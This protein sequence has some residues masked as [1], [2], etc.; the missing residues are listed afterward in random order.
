MA[1]LEFYGAAGTVTGSHHILHTDDGPVALDAG[2]FQGKRSEYRSR[3][4]TFPAP[5]RELQALLLSHAHID[6]SGNI[7]N[8]V[9]HRFRAPVYAT[10]ATCDLCDI[11][12]A[13]SAHIQEE[14]ARFW[15]EK[16]ARS[17][18]E[19]I[20][21]LYTV[22]D[23]HNAMQYFR[24]VSYDE[25]FEFAEGCKATFVDAGHILGS[26]C[27]L[28]EASNGR[29]P[30]TLLYTGDLGRFE[31]PILRDPTCP[32][33]KVDYL[34]TECTYASRRHANPTDM[35]EQLAWI[36]NQTR[37]AGGKVIIPAFSVGRTQNV[38]YYLSQA[39]AEGLM[40]PLPVFVDSPLST[41]ATE[42]FKKHPECYDDQARSFWWS[43]GDIFGRGLVTYI[44]DVED[45]KRLN[46]MNEPMVDFPR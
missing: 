7:P 28:I 29:A 31:M 44:T 39:V 10:A 4:T 27:V 23:A 15:N 34:I 32:M 26:A 9:R 12:L 35:K 40:E 37:D 11:M 2:L 14:D 24:E 25:P 20:E 6:H 21:P 22:E 38:V 16:R 18:A 42:V 3:N 13:D 1:E 8:L 17:R 45:S 33:P 41:H 46:R 30:V 19:Q 43:E 5:P 36:I